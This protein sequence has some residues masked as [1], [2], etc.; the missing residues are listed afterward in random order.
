MCKD[1]VFITTITPNGTTRPT[2]ANPSYSDSNQV[3][4]PYCSMFTSETSMLY[5][6]GPSNSAVIAPRTNVDNFVQVLSK[7]VFESDAL[8]KDANNVS[9]IIDVYKYENLLNAIAY[10]PAFCSIDRSILNCKKQV[11]AFMAVTKS[12]TDNLK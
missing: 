11:A 9:T 3:A 6:S 8:F 5:R 7:T 12:L 4:Q 1:N 2:T 10:F